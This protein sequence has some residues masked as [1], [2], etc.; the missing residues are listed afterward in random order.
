MQAL[1]F[2]RAGDPAD[3]L[4]LVDRALPPEQDGH[5]LVRVAARP[6]HPAD[7]AF[8]RGQYRVRPDFPQVAGLEGVG[9]VIAGPAGPTFGPGSRVAF[10]WP[11]SWAE[12]AAVPLNRLMAVPPDISNDDAS[13]IS[14]N[15]VTAWALLEQAAVAPEDW[16][17]LSAATSTVANLVAAMARQRGI[18]VI[19]LVRGEAV[20]ARGRSLAEIILSTRD[21]ELPSKVVGTT[22]ARRVGAFIDSVGGPLVQKLI[23]ALQAG[24]RIIAY[25]V[26]DRAP[27]EITNAMLIYSNL[28]WTGFGIDRYLSTLSDPAAAHMHGEL[29]AMIR[30]ATIALPI[31]S[32]HALDDFS[33][34]LAADAQSG[35]RGKVLLV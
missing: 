8:I 27:A 23:P 3:A 11:G 10:R 32:R 29:W 15:P 13:Q 35:R 28:T 1:V 26:Q 19:G 31:A 18:R 12:V 25:G 5:V 6:V 30:N 24:G 9:T 7:L 4:R 16:I 34:A 2:D 21:P 17:M 14:L 22:G 33:G 20:E